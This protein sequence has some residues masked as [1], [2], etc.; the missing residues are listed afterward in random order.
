MG[1][2]SAWHWLIVLAIAMLLF[3]RGKIPT[4]MTDIA[5]G[6]KNFKRG[7]AD[8]DTADPADPSPDRDR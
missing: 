6:I 3:G 1:S 8:N 7:I 5:V 4:L 2:F